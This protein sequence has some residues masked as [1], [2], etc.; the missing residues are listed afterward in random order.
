M[1]QKYTC[2]ICDSNPDQLSHH[3]SHLRTQ[4]HKDKR[5]I[6]ELQLNTMNNEDLEEKYET[7]NIEKII[8]SMETTIINNTPNNTIINETPNQNIT[9]TNSDSLREHIHSI[10]NYIRNHG[11]GYG[12][13]AL[14]IFNIFYGIKKLEDHHLNETI[15]L[16]H[17]YWFSTLL[18]KSSNLNDEEF[19][20]EIVNGLLNELYDSICLKNFFL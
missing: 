3:K 14:K 9:I 1:P 12:L 15:G 20:D 8:T 7:T 11:G 10:H 2:Q 5:A 13:S 19:H 18:E 4:R 16:S 17:H 6:F